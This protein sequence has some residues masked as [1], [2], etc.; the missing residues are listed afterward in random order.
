MRIEYDADIDKL[1]IFDDGTSIYSITGMSL[2][3]GGGSLHFFVS[4]YTSTAFTVKFGATA[5][6]GTPTTGF[7]ALNSANIYANDPPA[8]EEGE[9]YFNTITYTGNGGNQRIGPYYPIAEAYTIDNSALF[10]ASSSAKL[11]RTPGAAGN[12]RLW[13]FSTWVKRSKLSATQTIFSA[14]GANND[15]GNFVINFNGSDKID[16]TMWTLVGYLTTAVYKD[17]SAWYHIVLAVDTDNATANNRWRLYVNGSEVTALDTRN[18]PAINQDM[19]VNNTVLHSIGVPS[20]LSSQYFDG[21]QSHT[22][23][24]DGQA[25]TPAS[26]GQFDGDLNWVPKAYTGTYGTNGFLLDYAASGDL[27]ND[28]SGNAND[29]TNSNVTQVIDTPTD[30][31]TTL[32]PLLKYA[33][34]TTSKGNLLATPSG[35]NVQFIGTT[36]AIPTTGKWVWWA[37][38]Q[39]GTSVNLGIGDAT[40][41]VGLDVNNGTNLIFD[42]NTGAF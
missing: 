10:D 30:S 36:M 22:Y 8:I 34:V 27:G 9:K 1:E 11:T 35:T 17:T 19:A 23:L 7:L 12:R 21:Y 16:I 37:Q 28:V 15:A 29:F 13:T 24:I 39:S 20:N 40:A 4:T 31:Y 42:V 18:N 6:T 33:N 14:W 5:F 2:T 26:F 32:N 25:L 41:A 3:S 38:R